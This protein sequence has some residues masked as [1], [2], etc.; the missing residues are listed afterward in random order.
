M[1]HNDDWRG[2]I[3]RENDPCFMEISMPLE[4]C[5]MQVKICIPLESTE[6]MKNRKRFLVKLKTPIRKE[7]FQPTL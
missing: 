5:D 6:K 2:G 1:T 7:F 4:S 3:I